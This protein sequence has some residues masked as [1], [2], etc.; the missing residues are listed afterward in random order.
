LSQAGFTGEFLRT[1]LLPDW[2]DEACER[3]PSVMPD[4]DVRVARFLS[5][6]L[7]DVRDGRTSLAPA[8]QQ[9]AQLRRVRDVNRDRLAPAI[10]AAQQ[11]GAAVI[12]N[13]HDSVPAEPPPAQGATWRTAITRNGSAVVLDDIL[14]DLWRRG[15]PVVPIDVLPA[16]SFQ[17]AAFVLGDRPV[18][19]LGHKHDEPGRVAFLTAHEAGHIAAGDCSPD[20]PVIDEED[21]VGDESEMEQKADRFATEVLVGDGEIPALD[22]ATFKDLAKAA[23]RLEKA[24]GVDASMI[25]FSWAARTGTYGQ[26]SMA[27]KALYRASGARNL[28]GRHFERHV[29]LDAASESDRALLRCVYGHPERNAAAG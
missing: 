4:I 1:A 19:V 11:I 8:L 29:D 12:R 28:L 21:E 20:H 2:W 13:L 25:I 9:G 15:I 7:A 10:H 6:P 23:I 3:D 5:I 22:G 24:H 14:N 17:G 27:V 26:A 18:I 16:P